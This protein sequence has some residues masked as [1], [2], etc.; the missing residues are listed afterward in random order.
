MTS[1]LI[2]RY[3]AIEERAKQAAAR[4]CYAPPKLL[5]VSKFQA[6]SAM[7]ELAEYLLQCNRQVCFGE[8]YVQEYR[9]KRPQLPAHSVHMI[10]RLQRNKAREAV[11]LFDVIESVHSLALAETLQREAEKCQKKQIIYL[12]VNISNDEDKAGFRLNEFLQAWREIST[13]S[14]LQITGLMTITKIYPIVT[15]VRQ[16]FEMY[17]VT[18]KEN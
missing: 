6:V 5:A 14:N 3:L 1:P 17:K 9:A 4:F 13:F 18:M 11:E 12:Q 7:Q 8:S 10:G 15:D 16:D 2:S